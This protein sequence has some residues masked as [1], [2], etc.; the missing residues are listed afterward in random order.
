[1]ENKILFYD[2][3]TTGLDQ[4]WIVQLAWQC[5][6]AKDG[7]VTEGDVIIKPDGYE[8]PPE[9]TAIHGISH[10]HALEV[11]M[12]LKDAM[13][14]FR[15]SWKACD[16]I[17]GH[18]LQFDLK[19]LAFSIRSLGMS[20]VTDGKKLTCTMEKTTHLLKLPGK[21]GYKWAKLEELHRFL[22]KNDFDGAHN[23]MA[24]V[25]ATSKCYFELKKRGLL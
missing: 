23:A 4:P 20:V 19:A 1:M 7:L 5:Y 3:E 22:F 2:T 21:Y 12:Q 13:S 6:D 14:L 11:G 18:N 9:A 16:H 8:I 17:V 25:R 15:E 10:E 24:D